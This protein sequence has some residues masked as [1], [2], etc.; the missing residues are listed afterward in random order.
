MKSIINTIKKFNIISDT[1][2]YKQI[3]IIF[4]FIYFF[5]SYFS[6]LYTEKF[7]FNLLAQILSIFHHFIMYFIYFSFLAP[8]SI[9]YI[10][11]FINFFTL[12][13]WIINKNK[14]IITLLV[15]K[16]CKRNKNHR[17]QDITYFIS[18]NLDKYLIIIRIPLLIILLI[19]NLLR[20]FINKN[21]LLI[22]GHRG[23]RG[24]FPENTLS[25]FSYAIENNIDV[26]EL[27]TQITKDKEIIIYHDKKINNL[28]CNGKSLPIKELSLIQIKEYDCGSK[29][30]SD[31][32]KQKKIKNSKIPTLEELF[33][34]VNTK[35]ILSSIKFN[36]E[37]KTTED[38][39]SYEEV[40]EFTKKLIY[41]INKYRFK[42]RVI[43]QSFDIR[44]L[45]IVRNIDKNISTS[46]LIEN[47][48]INDKLL[49]QAKE[50]NIN[51]IS[52]EY[53]LLDKNIIDK[54]HSKGFKLIPWTINNKNILREMY[55]NNIYAIITDYPVEMYN[56]LIEYL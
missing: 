17:F 50:L 22:Q 13:F 2:F 33:H 5:L 29:Q 7:C 27:D 44:S 19:F 24:N 15:N 56:Y 28:I 10:L 9:L 38:I 23:A 36:I 51:F 41:L 52:P 6:E 14:C 21:K 37:I 26:I 54:I 16:L 3:F 34:L 18:K 49:Q 25:A 47:K 20:Y 39:D 43:I 46:L 42:S 45:N 55:N 35:Y 31:F 1:I 40:L 30:N 11:I 12:F 48:E 32:P 4:G 53:S 8:Y